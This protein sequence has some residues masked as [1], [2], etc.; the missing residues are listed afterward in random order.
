MTASTSPLTTAAAGTA[1]ASA[2]SASMRTG[3]GLRIAARRIR[4]RSVGS[5]GIAAL[6]VGRVV[7]TTSTAIIAATTAAIATATVTAS[8]CVVRPPATAAAAMFRTATR[9]LVRLVFAG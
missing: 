8:T 1:I 7:R 9:I 5:R 3:T 6:H 4:T 2:L